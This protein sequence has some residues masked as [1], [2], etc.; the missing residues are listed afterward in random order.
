MPPNHRSEQKTSGL[1]PGLQAQLIQVLSAWPQIEK[2]I[3][4]GSRA[5]GDAGARSDIDLCVVA[6][7]ATP[8]QWLDLV[9]QLQEA[10]TLLSID[11]VR[12]EE[13]TPA[14]KEKITTEGI[15][16]YEPGPSGPK[17]EQP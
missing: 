16:L 12:W 10:R 14:L 15:I 7:A 1:P 8:R 4:F 5:R 11:I 9:F 3:L 17:P 6:P 13:A 2:A